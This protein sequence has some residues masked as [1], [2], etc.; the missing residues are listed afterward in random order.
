MGHSLGEYAAACVAGV[1]PLEDAVRLVAARGRLTHELALEGAM[2]AVFAGEAVV[3]GALEAA[4]AGLAVAAE[5]GPEHFVLSGGRD[6][7]MQ[8]LS[9]L[10]AQGVRVKPLRVPHAAHSP[11]IEPVLPAFRRVL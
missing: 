11:Q 3:R 10:E 8:A 9:R 4:G 2:G 5:N 6:A 7:V 1:L